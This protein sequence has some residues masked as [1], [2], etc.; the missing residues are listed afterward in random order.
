MKLLLCD[1]SA[2][3]EAKMHQNGICDLKKL[4][5]YYRMGDVNR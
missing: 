1:S 5:N 4:L 3:E 2:P